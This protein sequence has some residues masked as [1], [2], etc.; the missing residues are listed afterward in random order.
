MSGCCREAEQD[1]AD[2]EGSF[3]LIP[4]ALTPFFWPGLWFSRSVRHTGAVIAPGA[5]L[6]LGTPMLQ[7][8]GRP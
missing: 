2:A 6:L 3:F 5:A 4:R 8:L 7:L 1:S